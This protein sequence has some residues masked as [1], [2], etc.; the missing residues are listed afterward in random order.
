MDSDPKFYAYNAK[1]NRRTSCASSAIFFSDFFETGTVFPEKSFL[2]AIIIVL[3]LPLRIVS[4]IRNFL[5][6]GLPQGSKPYP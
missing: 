1:C 3:F 6:A 4:E 5:T 2:E